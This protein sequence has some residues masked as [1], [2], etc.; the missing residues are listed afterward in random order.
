MINFDFHSISLLGWKGI[1]AVS[2]VCGAITGGALSLFLKNAGFNMASSRVQT[3]S[4]GCLLPVLA[5]LLTAIGFSQLIPDCWECGF[6]PDVTFVPLV[7]FPL[8]GLSASAVFFL[9]IWR[10]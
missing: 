1:E 9:T 2:L 10:R 5:A 6:T 8:M 7:I 4:G 3:F